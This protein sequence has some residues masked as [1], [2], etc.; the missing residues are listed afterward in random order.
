MPTSTTEV[1]IE[2]VP[3]QVEYEYT[4]GLK[5]SSYDVPDDAPYEL[6]NYHVSYTTQEGDVV[7][8]T[9]VAADAWKEL[10]EESINEDIEKWIW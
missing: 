6:E 3:F 7:D 5:N 1:E 8:V 9:V 4:L 2:G 10:I